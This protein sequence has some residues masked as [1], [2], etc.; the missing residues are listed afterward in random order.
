MDSRGY[1]K[2]T[3]Q[4]KSGIDADSFFEVLISDYSI[5]HHFESPRY[6]LE[7]IP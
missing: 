6:W 2:F 3:A 1:K 4:A 5:P 7:S